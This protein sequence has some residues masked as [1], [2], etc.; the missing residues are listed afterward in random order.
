MGG[1]VM[2]QP[3]SESKVEHTDGEQNTGNHKIPPYQPKLASRARLTLAAKSQSMSRLAVEQAADLLKVA[4]TRLAQ[5]ELTGEPTAN[6]LAAMVRLYRRPL[7]AFYLPEPPLRTSSGEDFRSLTAA[8]RMPEMEARLEAL[9]RDVRTRQL[10]VRNILTEDEEAIPVEFV[11]SLPRNISTSVLVSA[12]HKILALEIGYLRRQKNAEEVFKILR[13]AVEARGVF[14]LLVGDLGSHQTAI[15]ISTF[16]GFA[17]ADKWAPFIVIN[18]KDAKTAWS[19]TLIHE[20]AHLLTGSTGVSGDDDMS[21]LRSSI[22]GNSEPEDLMP[23][24]IEFARERRISPDLEIRQAKADDLKDS[25]G[26]NYYVVRRHRLGSLVTFARRALDAG[27]LS[28]TKAALVLGVKPRNVHANVL[29]SARDTYYDFNMVPEF[30]R[31]LEFHAGNGTI[32]MPN[33]TLSEIL[34]G[35]PKY[36]KDL[37]YDWVNQKSL[38][39]ALDL[40]PAKLEDVQRVLADGYGPAM[41]DEQIGALRADPFL[42]AHGL[43]NPAAPHTTVKYLMHA[44]VRLGFRGIVLDVLL[45]IGGK[46]RA[47]S[48]TPAQ[49]SR[50]LQLLCAVTLT[51]LPLPAINRITPRAT[52]IYREEIGAPWHTIAAIV[53]HPNILCSNDAF[54]VLALGIVLALASFWHRWWLINSSHFAAGQ[55]CGVLVLACRST[56]YVVTSVGIVLAQEHA[57]RCYC[58]IALGG[59]RPDS[60]W[61]MNW[62]FIP[63]CRE[64]IALITENLFRAVASKLGLRMMPDAMGMAALARIRRVQVL[65]LALLERVRVGGVRVSGPRAA[66]VGPRVVGVRAASVLP[67]KF[68]WMCVMVPYEA[69]GFGSQLQTVLAEPGMAEVLAACPQAVRILRPLCWALGVE[70]ADWVPGVVRPAGPG[71]RVRLVRVDPGVRAAARA[72]RVAAEEARLTAHYA[73]SGVPKRFWFRVPKRVWVGWGVGGAF[74]LFVWIATPPSGGSR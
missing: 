37:L 62:D 64:R 72:A 59:W 34:D 1:F 49:A 23:L 73:G 3:H 20:L 51:S 28:P 53:R 25:G 44:S 7:L 47:C 15:D 68:A 67:R 33:E 12:V 27:V 74:S 71:V 56:P 38:R 2:K 30:W 6:Q 46:R 45:I 40:G 8:T 48:S 10:L 17:L 36:G 63:S 26:A 24:V 66:A 69:A 18:D 32:R 21:S 31:W 35:T 4:A 14:V 13:R 61:W 11:G 54:K 55:A 29:I 9:L 16:R 60:R 65:V 42:V 5:I 39:N 70:R 52:P 22:A 50:K 43:A 58:G 57:L 19:F 41:T